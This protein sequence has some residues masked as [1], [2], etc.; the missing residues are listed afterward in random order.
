[1]LCFKSRSKSTKK[2]V[3]CGAGQSWPPLTFLLGEPAKGRLLEFVHFSL[4]SGSVAH[5]FLRATF[6]VVRTYGVPKNGYVARRTACS[7]TRS[8]A[9]YWGTTASYSGLANLPTLQQMSVV[10]VKRAVLK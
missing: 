6:A 3:C 5:A 1:M 4:S 7:T 2:E 9:A 8:H 10:S